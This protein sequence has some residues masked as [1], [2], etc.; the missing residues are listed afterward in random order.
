MSASFCG[1]SESFSRLADGMDLLRLLRG[2]PEALAAWLGE[3]RYRG[4]QIA[5]WI[6]ERG[7]ADFAAMT[8][9]PQRLRAC[10]GERLGTAAPAITETATAR[11]STKH[12]IALHDGESVECVAM[13]QSWGLSACLS[14]QVGCPIGCV[15]CAS[16]CDGLIRNLAP[17][18]I[19][20]QFL[21]LRLLHGPISHAVLM[22]MGE[23]LLNATATLEA[24]ELLCDGAAFSVPERNVTISTVGV[25][26][27]IAALAESGRRVRL[28]VS[29]HAA[30]PDLRARL[31]PR[32]PDRIA[33]VVAAARAYAEGARRRVTY[34]CVLIRDVNDDADHAVALA[35]LLG[36]GAHVNLI[37]V[38]AGPRD[39][40]S[41]PGEG[42][43]RRFGKVLADGGVNV[44]VRRSVGGSVRAACGQLRVRRRADARS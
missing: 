30:D 5:R 36:A 21:A 17:E 29:V 38:N 37:P 11:D 16:G 33:D 35:R 40:F 42:A 9:L 44:S 39:G 7:V 13:R 25:V 31:V 20:G 15:F 3:P 2:G 6:C 41:P 32:Q 27:G 43:V 23:P 28:A 19:A 1:Q 4:Q 12:L 18:E 26:R 8:D 14:T 10:L 24:L 22:G 34:E